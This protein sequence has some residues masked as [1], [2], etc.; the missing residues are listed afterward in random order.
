[1]KSWKSKISPKVSNLTFESILSKFRFKMKWTSSRTVS[2]ARGFEIFEAETTSVKS[3]FDTKAKKWQV[4]WFRKDPPWRQGLQST[5][6]GQPQG[7][8]QYRQQHQERQ[9][10]CCSHLQWSVPVLTT[11]P[12]F[13]SQARDLFLWNFLR[14]GKLTE[15][16]QIAYPG[17]AI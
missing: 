2:K 14:P 16:P 6:E 5:R 10:L 4:L 17:K 8:V 9:V 11:R 3:F 1:M 13:Q 7:Q 12:V 15:L